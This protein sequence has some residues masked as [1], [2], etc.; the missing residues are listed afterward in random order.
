MTSA[1]T[2]LIKSL[3]VGESELLGLKD[4]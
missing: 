4:E 1:V 3:A 2:D